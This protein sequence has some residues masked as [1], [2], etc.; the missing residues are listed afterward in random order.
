MPAPLAH[1]GGAPIMQAGLAEGLGSLFGGPIGQ[2]LA[3]AAGAGTAAALQALRPGL[4]PGGVFRV[5]GP[6]LVTRRL[7]RVTNPSTGN[8]VY[9]RNVGQPILFRG[10]LR[11]CK[12]VEKVARL[13]R[14]VSRKR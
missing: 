3:P 5:A 6:R 10:D 9:Y 13:A 7:L 1:P 8:D 12:T 4:A 2:F 14:R 11:V